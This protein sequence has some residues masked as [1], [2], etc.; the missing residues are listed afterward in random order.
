MTMPGAI[1]KP[2]DRSSHALSSLRTIATGSAWNAAGRGLPVIV[3]ILITPMLVRHLGIDR[4]GL[5]T[6]ALSLVGVA[7]ILDFGVSRALTRALAEA[8][9]ADERGTE[10]PLVTTALT[11]VLIVTVIGGAIGY[12]L[13][14]MLVDSVLNVP[15]A[16]HGQAVTA[17]RLLA[18]STPLIVVNVALTGV[19]AA[20]QRYRALNLLV[21]PVTTAYF[22]GPALAILAWDSLT[23]VMLALV[24]CRVAYTLG[25]AWIS[26]RLVPGLWGR[27]HFSIALLPSL[28]RISGWITISNTLTPLLLY[29]DRFLIAALMP[30]AA[31]SYYATPFDVVARYTILPIAVT[32]ALFP[33]IAASFRTAPET[34][35]TMLRNAAAAVAI[36]SFPP[37]ILTVAFA[38]ELLT[39]WLGS[40]FAVQSQM[41]LR[42]LAAGMFFSCIT[43]VLDSLF[44]GTGRPDVAA[45]LMIA[46]TALFLPLSAGAI[47]LLGIKGAALV[48]MLRTAIGC[49]GRVVLATK[50]CP[51]TT[52]LAR[53]FLIMLGVAAALLLAAMVSPSLT[54]R[55][56]F[57]VTALVGFSG[58]AL[59]CLL[60][61]ADFERLLQTVRLR[62]ASC[63]RS[64]LGVNP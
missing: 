48:F 44:D 64:S 8:I 41:I 54:A 59:L 28:L 49:A 4:W 55:V 29:A 57:T 46:M 21:I 50:Y 20:Y 39:L 16:L 23:A 12:A 15:A 26:F 6:L 38:P 32:G 45:K 10:A 62:P 25:C 63:Q 2:A 5:F 58:V 36:V 24:A 37:C 52:G 14:P 1:A 7:G 60:H 9:G 17:F 34:V 33:A 51:T 61:R 40:D 18:L 56:I 13:M 47:L 53:R 43:L 42:L 22:V 31:V 3:A 35:D 27:P 30:L 11:L 19:V